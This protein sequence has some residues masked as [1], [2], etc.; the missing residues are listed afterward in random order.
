M[1]I[2]KFGMLSDGFCCNATVKMLAFLALLAAKYIASLLHS[3][4]IW[5]I[6][7]SAV[8]ASNSQAP[9]IDDSQSQHV[10]NA[11]TDDNAVTDVLAQ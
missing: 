2:H 6:P 7:C 10:T 9:V 3:C 11:F 1:H 4:C 5:C 8:D